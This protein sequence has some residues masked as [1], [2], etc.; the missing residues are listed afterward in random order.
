MKNENKN[1]KNANKNELLTHF[2][3]ILKALKS[4]P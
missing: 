2:K 4:K 3:N 1:V